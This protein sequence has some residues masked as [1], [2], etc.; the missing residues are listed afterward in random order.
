VPGLLISD[1]SPSEDPLNSPPD[2]PE[3]TLID[4]PD[5]D[6]P[7]A[8]RG[9]KFGGAEFGPKAKTK[10]WITDP[11]GAPLAPSEPLALSGPPPGDD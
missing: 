3:N 5:A 8:I 6:A 7:P 2:S 10:D 11:P 4:P 9:K 1:P